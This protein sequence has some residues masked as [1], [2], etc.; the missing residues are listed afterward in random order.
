[1]MQKTYTTVSEPD[2]CDGW[3]GI[4][5]GDALWYPLWDENT[6]AN[7]CKNIVDIVGDSCR[8]NTSSDNTSSSTTSGH[9]S[10]KT[11]DTL[12]RKS[13]DNVLLSTA[14]TSTSSP[15][16]PTVEALSTSETV[17]GSGLAAVQHLRGIFDK[18]LELHQGQY[19]Q[20]HELIQQLVQSQQDTQRK[21]AEDFRLQL[22]AQQLQHAKLQQE[23]KENHQLELSRISRTESLSKCWKLLHTTEVSLSP[24]GTWAYLIEQGV[25]EQDDLQY[26]SEETIQKLA[27]L[28][29]PIPRAK[30]LALLSSR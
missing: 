14:T 27:S 20:Q 11:A 21:I 10:V 4:M 13:Q 12:S 29:K 26:C 25:T 6:V 22:E 7:A 18:Q 23:L 15:T 9:S 17:S 1:M 19:K 5:I 30:F 16:P 3:L 2:Y 8:L 24:A 28:L